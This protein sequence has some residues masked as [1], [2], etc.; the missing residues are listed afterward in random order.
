MGSGGSNGNM[1]SVNTA[2]AKKQAVKIQEDGL[3]KTQIIL[4]ERKLIVQRE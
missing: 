4:G 2:P 1:Y 3:Y